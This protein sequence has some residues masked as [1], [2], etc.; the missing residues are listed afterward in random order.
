MNRERISGIGINAPSGDGQSS[1]REDFP[2]FTSS[3]YEDDEAVDRALAR[4]VGRALR[5]HKQAGNSVAEWRDGRVVIVEPGDIPLL[6][7]I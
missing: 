5:D 7:E 6:E 3:S 1:E 4:A 2:V